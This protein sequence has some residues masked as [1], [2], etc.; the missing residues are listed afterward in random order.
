MVTESFNAEDHENSDSYCPNERKKK[1][2]LLTITTY[3]TLPV[4]FRA[5]MRTGL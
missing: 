4:F 5:I 2:V 1:P 3:L